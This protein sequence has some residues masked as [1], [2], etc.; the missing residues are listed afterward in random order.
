MVLQI[1]V[2][3]QNLVRKNPAPT[4]ELPYSNLAEKQIYVYTGEN[5]DLTFKAKDDT[6]VKDMYLRGPGDVNWNNTTDFGFSMGVVNNGVVTGGGTISDNKQEA[7]IKMTGV[8]K[9]KA[10]DRWTSFVVANDN[11]NFSSMPAGRDFNALDKDPDANLNLDIFSLSLKIK[12]LSMIL[13][14]QQKKLQQQTQIK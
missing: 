10:S 13:Q 11:D 5:T 3:Y 12:H 8:T 2:N 4:V 6:T 7:T 14:H 9:L 1:N